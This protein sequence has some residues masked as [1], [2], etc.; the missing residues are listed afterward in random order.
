MCIEVIQVLKQNNAHLFILLGWYVYRR[1]IGVRVKGVTEGVTGRDAIVLIK[2]WLSG[3][4]LSLQGFE[5][6]LLRNNC[7]IVERN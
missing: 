6:Q 3:T 2:S 7:A 4:S 5:A 1:G